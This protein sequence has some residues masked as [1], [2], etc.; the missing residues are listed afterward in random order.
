MKPPDPRLA[1]RL[2][3]NA[4]VT[5]TLQEPAV[6]GTFSVVDGAFRDVKY[7]S[8]GGQVS[9]DRQRIGVDVKL[10]QSPARR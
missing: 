1:G 10:E 6:A 4:R 2:S 7:Q 9:Y 3:A 5:G 8:F